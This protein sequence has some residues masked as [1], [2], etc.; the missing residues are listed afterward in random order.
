MNFKIEYEQEA[1][2]RWLAELPQIPG[3]MAYGATQR[4]AMAKAEALAL[5]VLAE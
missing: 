4:E 5:R 2:G 1:D 3:V